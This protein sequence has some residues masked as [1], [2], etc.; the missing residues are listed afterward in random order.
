MHGCDLSKASQTAAAGTSVD[1]VPRMRIERER[2]R[3]K[4]GERATLCQSQTDV[5]YEFLFALLHCIA[6]VG[7]L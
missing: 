7:G 5:S 2:E 4:G 6:V 3:K 1:H